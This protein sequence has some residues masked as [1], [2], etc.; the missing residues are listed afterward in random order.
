MSNEA[1]SIYTRCFVYSQTQ[2]QQILDIAASMGSSKPKLGKVVVNGVYREYTDMVRD[3]SQCRFADAVLVT[4][5]DIREMQFT[6]A[7]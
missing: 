6:E 7:E 5:G 2:R 4:R 3:M 1:S